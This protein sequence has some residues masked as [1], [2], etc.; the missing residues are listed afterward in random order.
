ME[1]STS[2]GYV[3][4][5][6]D[7]NGNWDIYGA[8]VDP[9]TDAV[10]DVFPV[11]EGAGSQT[12]PVVYGDTVVWQDY[13]NGNWDIYGARLTGVD[14]TN[15]TAG[16]AFA[17]CTAARAQTWPS[18]DG[19]TVVWQ[20]FRNKSWDIYGATLV[21]D[22]LAPSVTPLADPVCAAYAAQTHPQVAQELA[23]WQDMRDKAASASYGA[24]IWAKDM[25]RVTEFPIVVAK[26]DQV[27]PSLSYDTVVWEDARA[28]DSDVYGATVTPWS[29]YVQVGNGSGWTK[30]RN[31]TVHML[32]VTTDVNPPVAEMVVF[33]EGDVLYDWRPFGPT[34]GMLLPAGDGPQEAG[35]QV[36]RLERPR[37]PFAVDDDQ[38]RHDAARD[39]E[40]PTPWPCSRAG[41]R[42]CR[43]A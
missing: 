36:R 19:T 12:R 24:D 33:N 29:I 37:L 10:K 13:R 31:L 27:L 41:W 25:S 1:P 9:D 23:V 35:H 5:Q 40:P 21:G 30:T 3:V 38:A 4:W 8:V 22:G 26:G 39:E 43:T 7:R 17:V 16:P 15:W 42:T 32:D 34:Y 28:G 14:A 20:D 18:T 6:D 11:Y 2:D